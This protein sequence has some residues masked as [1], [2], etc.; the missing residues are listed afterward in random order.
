MPTLT[1]LPPCPNRLIYTECLLGLSVSQTGVKVGASR[2]SYH[3]RAEF[4]IM[5][6]LTVALRRV[7]AGHNCPEGT[8]TTRERL[9]CISR[10]STILAVEH[11]ARDSDTRL[12]SRT[13]AYMKL[14]V[15]AHPPV[16][17]MSPLP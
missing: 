11:G 1:V 14:P 2:Y 12:G 9:L 6:T 3:G 8:Q 10:V 4:I 5:P 16:S 15:S 13:S 7:V 17:T